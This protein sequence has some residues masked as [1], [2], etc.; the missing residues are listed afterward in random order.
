MHESWKIVRGKN[1][2]RQVPQSKGHEFQAEA[3]VSKSKAYGAYQPPKKVIDKLQKLAKEIE[4]ATRSRRLL[5]P[6]MLVN[7]S[8]LSLTHF[9][10]QGSNPWRLIKARVNLLR[11]AVNFDKRRNVRSAFHPL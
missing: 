6:T 1:G 5:M 8:L 4:S 7:A 9:M 3:S 2:A 11:K 10:D